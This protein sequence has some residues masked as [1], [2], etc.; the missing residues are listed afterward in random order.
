MEPLR[1]QD[2]DNVGPYRLRARLGAGGMGR[3]Y[4]GALPDGALVA[5]KVV[6]PGFAHDERFRARFRREVEISRRVTGPWVA[7]VVDADPEAEQ[8]WLATQY[9]R[10]PS[11]GAAVEAH[12]P[13]PADTVQVLAHGGC[14]AGRD[15]RGGPGAP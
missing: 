9:V 12:G 13:L 5:I 15:P 11:L 4:L 14:R 3:V 1:A 2:P 6:H 7:A 10:G 8:P